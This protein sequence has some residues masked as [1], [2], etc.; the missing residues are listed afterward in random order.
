MRHIIFALLLGISSTWAVAQGSAPKKPLQLADDAPDR[1]V[2]VKGDTLWAIS[3]RFLKDPF[4][5]GELWR[6]N[7]DEVRNPHLI[8]PGQVLVLDRSGATPRLTLE[9][10]KLQPR[11]YVEPLRKQIPAIPPQVIEPFLTQQLVVEADALDPAARVVGIEDKRVIAAAGMKIFATNVSQNVRDWQVFRPGKALKDPDTGEVLG[12]EALSL[13]SAQLLREGNPAEFMLRVSK[14]EVSAG[15]H[16]LP[17]PRPDI[18]SYIPRAPEKAIS[19]R[20][21]SIQGGVNY[22]GGLGIVTLNR[23]KVD[24]IEVGHVFAVDTAGAM[25]DDRFKGEKTTMK[26]PD[27]K[28][29]LIFVFR[30]FN[31]VSYALVMDAARPVAIGDSIRTP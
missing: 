26:M 8:Y 21:L 14:Q 15:D 5:W 23:G 27:Q 9:T 6:M 7:K 13:G 18:I 10:V 20:V 19:G 2:V 24:G 12:H 29:G 16:L 17:T 3:A 28:N 22:T 4:R 1:H 11:E 30:V 25:V 31:R